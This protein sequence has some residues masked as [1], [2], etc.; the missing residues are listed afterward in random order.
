MGLSAACAMVLI[1]VAGPAQ[2]LEPKWPAGAYRYIVVDQDLR[3]ILVEFGRNL[4]VTVKVSEQVSVRRI[5]GRLP[6]LSAKEFLNRLCESYGLVWYF[7]G[8]VLHISGVSEIRTEPV[9]I[10][11]GNFGNVSEK[12]QAL[13]IADPRFTIRSTADSRILSVSGPPPYIA[14]IRQTVTAMQ[15]SVA[16]RSVREVQDGDDVK[17]RVFRGKAGEGS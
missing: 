10:G 9:D 3:D 15:K 6:V 13:G 8:A 2:S 14:L 5:R 7:D 4:N 16:P 11:P 1:A 12:L 17:V